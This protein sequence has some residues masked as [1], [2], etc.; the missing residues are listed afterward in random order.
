MSLVIAIA[1][2]LLLLC[3]CCHAGLLNTI[4]H[5]K[6]AFGAPIVAIA[7]GTHLANASPD[8]LQRV[9]QT[10]LEMESVQHVYL[11]HCS[12]Y[13]AFHALLLTLGPHIVRPC[14]AGTRLEF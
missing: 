3:G 8:H 14:P 11:N 13:V 4:A 2:G 10:L 5:V 12:G 7:G 6:R 1:S 9:G